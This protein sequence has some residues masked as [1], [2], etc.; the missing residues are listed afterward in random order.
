MD[1]GVVLVVDGDAQ[2]G[3]CEEDAEKE[4][5]PASGVAVT[6]ARHGN[7]SRLAT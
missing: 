4:R 7:R 1:L 3:E 2:S 6:Y 5:R